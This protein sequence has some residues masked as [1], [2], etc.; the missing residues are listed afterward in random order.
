[1][2]SVDIEVKGQPLYLE[3]GKFAK[4]ADGSVIVKYGDTVVLATAVAKKEA[5]KDIDFFPLSVDYREHSVVAK[6][7]ELPVRVEIRPQSKTSV[8]AA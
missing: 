5:R 1:M 8:L 7:I 4:Q 6:Y 3:T 2:T